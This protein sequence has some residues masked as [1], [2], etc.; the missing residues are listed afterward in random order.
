[1]ATKYK[2]QLIEIV[3]MKDKFLKAF[4]KYKWKNYFN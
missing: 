3:E 4:N 2:L 1:M